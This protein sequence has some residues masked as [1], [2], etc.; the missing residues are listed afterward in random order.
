VKTL[1][2]FSFFLKLWILFLFICGRTMAMAAM[3]MVSAG[4]FWGMGFQ[5]KK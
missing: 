4:G 5:K 2:K 3:E 1:P